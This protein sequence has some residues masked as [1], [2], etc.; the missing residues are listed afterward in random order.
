MSEPE[1]SI[2]RQSSLDRIN[3]P[4]RMK[5]YIKVTN[6]GAW[7]AILAIAI[8]LVAGLF[9]AIFG[10]VETNVDTVGIAKDNVIYCLI[11]DTEVHTIKQGMTAKIGTLETT[12][13]NV[14]ERPYS[15]E[16]I[17][18]KIGKQIGEYEMYLF[19]LDENGWYYLVQ[20]ENVKN[21]KENLSGKTNVSIVTEVINPISFIW[22]NKG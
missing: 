2:F 3:S 22:S 6:F 12:V 13:T 16:Q 15:T 9:W 4:D 1:K 18:K 19:S 10:R 8:I 7:A 20:L 21:G 11:P 14:S 5:D 17:G